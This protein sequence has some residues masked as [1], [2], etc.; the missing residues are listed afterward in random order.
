MVRN[1]PRHDRP[2]PDHRVAPHV[3][4]RHDDR[5][6]ADRAA[7]PQMDRGDLPIVGPG[8]VAGG[9]HGPRIAVVRED[10]MRSDEGAVLRRHAVIDERRVSDLD[11]VAEGDALVD[12]HVA[13]DDAIGPD[14]RPDSELGPMPHARA[15]TH[16]DTGL[17]VRRR[18]DTRRGVDHLRAAPA[19]AD[20]APAGARASPRQSSSVRT[21]P[22]IRRPITSN[23]PLPR[24]I[25]TWLA[26]TV[27]ANDCSRC[28]SRASTER[29]APRLSS[30]WPAIAAPTPPI[31]T[32]SR[33]ARAA[34]TP[35][36]ETLTVVA[37]S[38]PMPPWWTS[39]VSARAA[40]MPP[41]SMWTLR[42]STSMAPPRVISTRSA[43]I[44]DRLSPAGA[45]TTAT[46]SIASASSPARVA[47][48]ATGRTRA[49]D[50]RGRSSGRSSAVAGRP[51]ALPGS[52]LDHDPATSRAASAPADR[53]SS[54]RPAPFVTWFDIRN[55]LVH[56]ALAAR[57][58]IRALRP[59][60]R[61]SSAR[62]RHRRLLA[63]CSVRWLQM[64]DRVC[65]AGRMAYAAR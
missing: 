34:P 35:P 16:A 7:F 8:Q 55:V 27:W 22:S 33:S 54:G 52:V 19:P 6:R 36:C 40:P 31:S 1:R 61:A 13:T 38:R 45:S 53:S 39:T 63:C 26:T 2:G 12:E 56:S 42:A 49:R 20:S 29:A 17:Q 60:Y 28:A 25:V 44:A 64:P 57:P 58:T 14:T 43:P 62:V 48:A 4:A 37:T 10:G 47:P 5:S 50:T 3:R 59:A 51:V 32:V 21:S 46:R 11:P 41:R 15:G 24:P 18:V 65:F 9:G 23:A 30:K